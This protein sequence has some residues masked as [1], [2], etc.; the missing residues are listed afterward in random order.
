ME[1]VKVFQICRSCGSTNTF[2][3]SEENTTTLR[4]Q[5]AMAAMQAYI[6]CDAEGT[7]FWN[8]EK[9]GKEITETCYMWAN[10]MME[11]RK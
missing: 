9:H 10:A 1:E 7:T 4:D 8:F 3:I 5:F 6:S 2:S 11:A